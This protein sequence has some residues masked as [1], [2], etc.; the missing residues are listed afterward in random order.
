MKIVV[1]LL[2]RCDGPKLNIAFY[3]YEDNLI[4]TTANSPNSCGSAL[5]NL[6]GNQATEVILY[7]I[8]Y[9]SDSIHGMF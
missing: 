3:S 4:P 8:N 6:F 9:S 1:P 5:Q 2:R 7:T